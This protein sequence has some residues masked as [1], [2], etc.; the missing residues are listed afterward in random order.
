[1]GRIPGLPNHLGG[2]GYVTH[3]D[4]G[5]IK[6][7]RD[8]LNCKSMLDIGCGVGGQVYEAINLGLDAKGVDGDFVTKR[9]NPALFLLHDFT[10]GKVENFKNNFDMI[11]CCEF[12]E[13]VAKEYEDNW[14][15]LMQLGKYVFVT[16]SIPGKPGHHHVNCEPLDYWLALYDKYGFD[17]EEELTKKSKSVSTMKREFWKDCGLI[18]KRR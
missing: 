5:L 10:K 17:Y 11:W 16:Y 1:M 13:H 14:M 2:H 6:F 4:V 9:D 18:F 15:P 7:A 12:I 3:T 8:E